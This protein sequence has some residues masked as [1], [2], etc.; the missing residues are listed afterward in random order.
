MK[1]QER[2]FTLFTLSRWICF[3]LLGVI[4]T[5][6]CKHGALITNV[7]RAPT[8]PFVFKTNINI[9]GSVKDKQQLVDRLQ[10]QLDDS[11][12]TRVISY[13]GVVKHIVRPPVFDTA[14]IS[15]SLL[16]IKALLNAEGYFSP[17][18]TYKTDT[19][20]Y[21]P[22]RRKKP[23]E[24]RITVSFRVVPGK[25][26]RL[27][28]I[29][30][31]LASPE[32]QKLIM[33]RRH[34]SLLKKG[35]PFSV[36][37]ISNE[38]D[39]MVN[40][41]RNNGYY[42]MTRELIY[43]ERDTVV[44]ALIDPTLDLFEQLAL[45]DS[46]QRKRENPTI[47]VVFKQRPTADST[48][49]LQ[50][51]IGD[52]TVHPDATILEDT[53]NVKDTTTVGLYKFITNTNR[54]KLPFIA[55]KIR[56]VPGR[57]YRQDA[58]YRTV[59]NFTALSAWAAVDLATEER[60]DSVPLVDATLKLYPEKKQ[61]L[62]VDYEV[63]RNV[64]DFITTGQL[65]GLGVN[66]RLTNRNAYRE[67]IQTSTNARF[68]IELGSNFIQT[69]QA[70]FAHTINISRFLGRIGGVSA[71]AVGQRTIVN[72]NAAYTDRRDFFQVRSL[73]ASWGYE[74]TL[75]PSRAVQP[76][77]GR[78][79]SITKQSLP[80]NFEY[81]IVNKTDS[82]KTLQNTIPSYQFAF[83]DGLIIGRSFG[84]SAGREVN[85]K[86]Y[87]GRARLEWSGLFLG[88]IKKLDQGDLRRFVK[89]DAEFKHYINYPKSSW[90]FRAFAGYGFVFGKTDTLGN[91]NAADI[92]D[93]NN[94][95]FF[96]A[97][98]G[99]GPY[100]MRAWP[101]RR[102]GPGSSVLYDTAKRERFGNIQ[103]ELNAEYR[104][105]VTTIA[106]IKLNSA[107]FVDIGNIWSTEYEKNTNQKIE[108]ASFSFGRLYKDIAIGAG[109]SLRLDFDFFMIRL[110]WAYRLKDPAFA[111]IRDGWF[112][113]L[114]LLDGQFQLG[115]GVPF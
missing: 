102:I 58:Y 4:L 110:D 14:N 21:H 65:F 8:K 41:F 24:T 5:T 83:N 107:L 54:F 39:R 56:L 70:S 62:T 115:I 73:N 38:I 37:V 40:L 71:N 108:E 12:K 11:L 1:L 99:G 66:V 19:S 60:Y 10:N 106:G 28:S 79:W 57:L 91:G 17:E 15:R 67:A 16:F 109:T 97:F 45:L 114:K 51:Y 113:D 75:R 112:H 72:L 64:S 74:W 95:P 46:L 44:A 52:V 25:V 29:G 47:N 104:F 68:G 50:F 27:D 20:V 98:F 63:S 86:F 82:L 31:D 101:I 53:F 36:N 30:Y 85:N 100:S 59:N 26:T 105:N 78:G 22:G 84:I 32:L 61:S 23:V 3:T 69:L 55:R 93:E 111:Y 77:P 103:I 43:A 88:M 9:P 87:L 48:H 42:K 94:L 96:K 90:A 89:V 13:A 81:A 34:E 76:E 92:V 2:Q 18:I 6:S 80:I 33:E 7:V 49:L 35:D